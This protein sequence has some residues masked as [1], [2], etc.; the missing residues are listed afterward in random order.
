MSGET[1]V[2]WY[3]SRLNPVM[4][5]WF[6]YIA[7][8][9]RGTERHVQPPTDATAALNFTHIATA[10]GVNSIYRRTRKYQQ[11]TYKTE[12]SNEQMLTYLLYLLNYCKQYKLILHSNFHHKFFLYHKP[13]TYFSNFPS[14]TYIQSWNAL[15]LLHFQSCSTVAVSFGG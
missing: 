11:L 10:E 9:C 13:A 7:G 3:C 1:C 15:K 14:S 4:C 12:E 2:W 8:A 5:N 6:H